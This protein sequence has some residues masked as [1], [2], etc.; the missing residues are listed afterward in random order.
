M[1]TFLA[2]Q[3]GD[4]EPQALLLILANKA[5]VERGLKSDDFK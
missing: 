4:A 2:E 5:R 3:M 1:T